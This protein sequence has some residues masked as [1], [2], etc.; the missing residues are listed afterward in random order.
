MK[1]LIS[2][3][4]VELYIDQTGKLWLNVDDVCTVRIGKVRQYN[5]KTPRKTIEGEFY[6]ERDK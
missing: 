2:A 4:V 1:D 6:G 3:D 5:I